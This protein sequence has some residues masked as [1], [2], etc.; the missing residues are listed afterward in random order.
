LLATQE[1]KGFAGFA[2]SLGYPA[3]LT[4]FQ[5]GAH[6]HEIYFINRG[7]IK[8]LHL[9]AEGRELI[10]NLRYPGCLLG[11]ASVLLLR[12]CPVTAVTVTPCSLQ[13]V[14]AAD[15]R[16]HLTVDPKLGW[17][18]HQ[19]QSWEIYEQT[20]RLAQ[21]GDRVVR[22][23]LEEVLWQMLSVLAPDPS[24]AGVKVQLPLKDKEIA[25][26]ISATPEHVSR[27]FKQLHEAGLVR[28]AKGWTI[29]PDPRRLWHADTPERNYAYLDQN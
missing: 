19:M 5:Q 24:P 25:Q 11:A 12:P 4:L 17:Y 29:I 16:Q 26:L 22:H 6:L 13:R 21:M 7:L 9:D 15:F 18:L 20:A 1:W 3:G 2:P 28:R 23:R 10:V 27:L 14:S 8:L